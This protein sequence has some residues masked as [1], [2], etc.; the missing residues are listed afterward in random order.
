M[1][2]IIAVICTLVEQGLPFRGDN[3]H[4]GSPN[5]GNYLGL[6]ELVAKFD[7]FLLAHI[8]RYGHSGSDNPSSFMADFVFNYFTI[9]LEIDFRKCHGQSYDN[10]ANMAGKYNGMQQKIIE[11]NQF[12]KFIPCAGHSLNLVGRSVVDCCLDAVNSFDIVNEIYSFFSSSTK[13]WAVLKSFLPPRSKVP[14]YLSDTRWN[15]HTKATEAVLESYSDITD[16]LSHLY[17]DVNGKGE[18]RLQANNLL[19]KTEELESVFM[20]PFWTASKQEIKQGVELLMKAYSEDTDLKRL[21]ELLHFHLFMVTNCSGERSFSRLKRIKN[22]L[23]ATMFQER[24]SALSIM[25]TE[26]DKLRQ[27]NFDEVLEEKL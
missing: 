17:S 10:T 19:Q 8:N 20:L 14:K 15:T 4:F 3:E 13:R 1:E 18:T 5:N 6:L 23:R 25:Y 11:K 16:A 27:T 12:A 7:P 26:S 9:E 22:E 24:L 2:R 21:D